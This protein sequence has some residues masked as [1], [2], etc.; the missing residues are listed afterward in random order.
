M[1]GILTITT[2]RFTRKSVLDSWKSE[3]IGVDTFLD[4]TDEGEQGSLTIDK[5]DQWG[6]ALDMVEVSIEFEPYAAEW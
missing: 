3:V 5:R 1:R 2:L 6:Q 4:A